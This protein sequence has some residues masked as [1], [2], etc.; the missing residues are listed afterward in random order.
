MRES[1]LVVDDEN[2][3]R[4]ILCDTLEAAGYAPHEAASAEEGLEFAGRERVDAAIVDLR[5]PGM[6]GLSLADRL[7]KED[8]DRPVLLM[9]AYGDLET[10][11]RSVSLG[12]YRYL[13][14]PLKFSELLLDLGRALDHRR[15]ALEN[16]AY[17]DDLEKRVE[18]RTAQ[19]NEKTHMGQIFLDALPCVGL[20]L[21]PDREIVVFNKEAKNAGVVPG[22]KCF[23]AWGKREA[24]CPWCLAPRALATGT[25]QHLEVEE[26]GSV[27]DTYWVP[28]APDRYLHYAFDVTERRKMEEELIRTQRLRAVN[29]LSAGISHNLNNILTSILG[30][31]QLLRRMT[32]DPDLLTEIDDIA[33]SANRAKE[34]VHRLHLSTR[35]SRGEGVEP[36][37]VS[38]VVHE[39]VRATR[40]RW[41]D[42]A[43]ARGVAFDVVTQVGDVPLI[44]GT[45]SGLHEMLVNMV[46]NALD[47]L[48]GGGTITISA[49][50]VDGHV[51][52]KVI[53]TGIGM[54]QQTCSRVFEPFYTT[55]PEVGT[56]LGMSTAYNAITEWGGAIHVESAPGEGTTFRLRLPVWSDTDTRHGKVRTARRARHG[57]LLIVEDDASVGRFLTRAMRQHHETELFGSGSDALAAFS[58]GRYDVALIDL[59]MRGMSGDQVA[60]EMK[61]VDPKIALVLVTGWELTADDDRRAAFDFVLQKPLDNLAEVGDTLA[62]AIQLRDNRNTAE[63]DTTD[64]GGQEP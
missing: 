11:K 49:R 14:K 47:A 42:Q 30:P 3:V 28:I 58:A 51:E 33:A 13:T 12:I 43:E 8:P 63:K 44:K 59:G 23:E 21:N 31:A 6:D 4:R 55:K 34:L 60:R 27:F 16:K 40:P 26:S 41:K 9:T 48:P 18:E 20:V 29:E 17:R 45:A 19:L 35:S 57:K 61:Q 25:A 50:T 62:R 7:L 5:M 37:P 53:D 38:S 56:G 22:T 24:P 39:A 36:V 32:D 15:L 1:V 2:D 10:A 54:D 46:F 52:L 64:G